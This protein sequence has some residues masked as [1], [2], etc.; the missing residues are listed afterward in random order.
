MVLLIYF[1]TQ[2]LYYYTYTYI[3]YNKTTIQ[4]ETILTPSA[5]LEHVSNQCLVDYTVNLE[6]RIKE[7]WSVS[8]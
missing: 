1:F 8:T 5:A 6:T 7:K 2:S 3:I 4:K